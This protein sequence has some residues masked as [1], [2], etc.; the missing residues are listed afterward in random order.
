MLD[1][2]NATARKGI[3]MIDVSRGF[4]KDG[5][6]N[7]LRE[8]DIH[9]IVDTFRKQVDVPRYARRVPFDEIAGAKNDYNLNLPRYI[10]ST[11]PE[12][13]QDIHA[14]LNGGIPERDIGGDETA[15][16]PAP[17]LGRYWA[18][19]PSLRKALFQGNGQAGYS[20]LAVETQQIKATILEHQEFAAFRAQVTECF[21]RWRTGNTPRLKGFAQ[22]GHPKELITAIGEALLDS[23]RAVPLLDPYDVYQ[24]LMDY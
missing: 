15:I 13:I 16:P 1:K 2:E 22:G 8:Q 18:V 5:N 11:E 9:R 14:H 19:F 3:F 12:D 10:D 4:I 24:H 7:R 20:E 23:F 21:A 6:K 17:G